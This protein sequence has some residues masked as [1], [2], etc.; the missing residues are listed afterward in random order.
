MKI[1]FE[2]KIRDRDIWVIATLGAPEPDVGIMGR[3]VE[4]LEARFDGE[5]P[6]GPP[7]TLT[8]E[9]EKIL[10]GRA[11]AIGDGMDDQDGD[12]GDAG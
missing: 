1:D 5:D 6:A 3:Y 11:C 9:E 12:D 8:E 7:I 4:H 2:A 10:N